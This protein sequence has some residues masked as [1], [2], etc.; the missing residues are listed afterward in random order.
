MISGDSAA[1]LAIWDLN[2]RYAA[3]LDGR[4][5]AGWPALFA[6]DGEYKIISAENVARGH[7]LPLLHYTH[8]PMMRDRMAVLKEAAIFT[9]AAERRIFGNLS[10]QQTGPGRYQAGA[11]FA[12]YRTDNIDG[13]TAL[14]VVGRYEDDIVL[15]GGRATFKARHVLLDTFSVPNHIGFPL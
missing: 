15:D 1:F 14:F 12:I 13:N 8:A 3:A 4:D 5:Y 2:V 10:F 7:A 11:S 6:E 9:R